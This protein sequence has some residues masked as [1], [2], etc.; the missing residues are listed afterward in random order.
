MDPGTIEFVRRALALKDTPRKGWTRAG[1]ARPES[2]ADHTWGVLLLALVAAE[3]RPGL[4]RARLLEVA[5]AHDLAE[6]VTGDLVPG[7]YKDKAEK[8]A[9]E[10]AAM[11]ALVEW[12]PLALRTRLIARFEEYATGASEEAKLVHDLDK[13]EMAFQADRYA[14]LGVARADLEP[15]LGSA[16]AAVQDA[17]MRA[18]VDRLRS[19]SD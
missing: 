5:L 14:S 3:S 17:A 10:R 4:D 18:T 11:E 16:S 7:D 19:A 13:L 6:A 15:F 8:L 12:A 9:R 1:V 2:V